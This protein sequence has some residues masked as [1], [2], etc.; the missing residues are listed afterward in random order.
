[1]S[2]RVQLDHLLLDVDFLH[3]PTIV[4]FRRKFGYAAIT[5]LIEVYCQMSRASGALVTKDLIL[6]I[7]EDMRFENGE[8]MLQYSLDNGLIIQIDDDPVNPF[9]SNKRV[10]KDQEAFSKKKKAKAEANQKYRSGD[11]PEL[12]PSKLTGTQKVNSPDS[13]TD[14]DTDSEINKKISKPIPVV[15]TCVKKS[16]PGGTP[17]PP[18]QPAS[19]KPPENLSPEHLEL[20]KTAEACFGPIAEDDTF[21][22]SNAWIQN[23]R[24]PMKNYPHVWLSPK[25]VFEIL[26]IYK[27]S[28][29]ELHEAKL[30]FQKAQAKASNASENGPT[31]DRKDVYG[32]L[33]SF[34]LND[35]LAV[36]TQAIRAEGA[37]NKWQQ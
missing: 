19:C 34:I 21:L 37:Q 15:E 1:M 26:V 6:A 5:W 24:R 11:T 20:W 10:I 7:A 12:S 17:R 32:W 27:D 29:L 13:D 9:Y 3:K 18:G 23:G 36:K 25:Q 16:D 14:T 33:T 35:V 31:P 30:C 28:G 8:A 4:P 2:E 22:K